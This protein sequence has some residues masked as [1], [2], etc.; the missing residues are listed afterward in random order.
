MVPDLCTVACSLSAGSCPLG[1]AQLCP[2]LRGGDGG[3]QQLFRLMSEGM[4]SWSPSS[5]WQHEGH[6]EAL[7]SIWQQE[8]VFVIAA[9]RWY[10]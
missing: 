1:L 10:Y 4:P 8:E 5:G 9:G 7:G 2:V 3:L 6:A